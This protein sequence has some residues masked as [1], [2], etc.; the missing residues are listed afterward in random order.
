MLD[1]IGAGATATS[2]VNWYDIWNSAP[3]SKHLQEELENIHIEGRNRP[4]V[5]AAIHSEFAAPWSYQ[6]WELVKRD[7][8][9]HWRDPSY[10]VA[11]IIL[12][13]FGGLFIGFTFFQAADS[14][15]GT[16]NKLFVSSYQICTPNTVDSRLSSRQFLWRL[17]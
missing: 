11:K 16:Q 5:A 4:A 6:T 9:A 14:Q 10:L 3:E 7:S 8:E 13:G 2:A 12:N 17:F 15:Q 1:V